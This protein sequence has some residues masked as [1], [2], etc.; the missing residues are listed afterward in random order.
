MIIALTFET[1]YLKFV[2][3]ISSKYNK[4]FEIAP[5][6]LFLIIYSLLILHKSLHTAIKKEYNLLNIYHARISKFSFIVFNIF[7]LAGIVLLIYF[8]VICSQINFN[9]IFI[10]ILD[11]LDK[12]QLN[13]I[14]DI[15]FL[16]LILII[17]GNSLNVGDFFVQIL[18][19]PI[20]KQY[21]PANLKNKFY[22]I[23][24]RKKQSSLSDPLVD[25]LSN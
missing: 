15:S 7:I 19:H 13:Y 5:I 6:L 2:R 9:S 22:K 11:K 25:N 21:F 23:V 3:N 16:G 20:E 24:I 18:F 1:I 17:L 8:L 14:K 10:F 4:Y 12:L